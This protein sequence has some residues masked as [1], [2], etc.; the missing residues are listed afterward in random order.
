M[1]NCFMK[2]VSG[3]TYVCLTCIL[4]S[5]LHIILHHPFTEQ[6]LTSTTVFKVGSSHP[7]ASWR[8]V[9]LQAKTIG[10]CMKVE[11]G[12]SVNWLHKNTWVM[13]CLGWWS[14]K[15]YVLVIFTSYD[16][17]VRKESGLATATLDVLSWCAWPTVDHEPLHISADHSIDNEL[18]HSQLI[19]VV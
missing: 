8:L 4:A 7:N 3:C 18:S 13:R 6:P 5:D 11:V 16:L 15:H 19:A 1:L 12:H 2:A 10:T 9:Y 17:L 14:E